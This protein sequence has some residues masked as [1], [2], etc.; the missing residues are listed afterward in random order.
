MEDVLPLLERESMSDEELVAYYEH[1]ALQPGQPRASIE[2]PL[3][4]MLPFDHVDHTH[5]DA[6]IA[7]CAAP[8]GRRAGRTPVGRQSDLGGVRA[9][10]ASAW[11]KR[12]RSPC[13]SDPTPRAC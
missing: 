1:A 13:A 11:A 2:T 3:H 9:A 10:Q 6:I 7:L 12:L 4:S 8:Q 5:P